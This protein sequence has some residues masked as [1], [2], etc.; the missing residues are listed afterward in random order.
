MKTPRRS[1]PVRPFS[2]SAAF[3]LAHPC[4]TIQQPWAELILLADKDVENRSW[5][6][7]HRGPLLIHAGMNLV[8]KATQA[9]YIAHS[10]GYENFPFDRLDYG[11][12][13]GVVDVVDCVTKHA[14][15]YFGGPFG[16]VLA[17]PRRFTRPLPMKGRL[18]MFHLRHTDLPPGLN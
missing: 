12:V 3:L 15:P 14:S 13:I 8:S 2:P 7:K 18:G 6:T 5:R 4:L 17:N 16:F 1:A 11:A 10:P 9:D